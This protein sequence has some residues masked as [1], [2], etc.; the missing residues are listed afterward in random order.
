MLFFEVDIID[1]IFM[2]TYTFFWAIVI[3]IQ[4]GVLYIELKPKMFKK[5][6]KERPGSIVE[7]EED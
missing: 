3:V 5:H 7:N 6:L 2:L 1:V 4:V